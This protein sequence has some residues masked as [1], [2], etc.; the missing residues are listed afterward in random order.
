MKRLLPLLF[1]LL[2]SG[3]YWNQKQQF[4]A[5]A[6]EAGRH[7]LREDSDYVEACMRAHGYAI[8]QDQCPKVLREDPQRPDPAALEAMSNELRR[9]YLEQ[10]EKQVAGLAA[11]RKAEPTCYEPIGWFGKRAL[12]IEKWAWDLKLGH[13]S[14]EDAQIELIECAAFQSEI[15]PSLGETIYKELRNIGIQPAAIQP[16]PA[17]ANA[18]TVK[19]DR[20]VVSARWN[21]GVTAGKELVEKRD[22]AGIAKYLKSCVGTFNDALRD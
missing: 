17:L 14:K 8:N 10:I 12:R 21:K 3:C 2:L 20:T 13:K 18:Y 22:V 6:L 4:G 5:C 19:F 11:Y 16:I 1:A 7:T 9:A 15:P